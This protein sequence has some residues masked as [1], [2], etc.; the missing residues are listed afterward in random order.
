[1]CRETKYGTVLT[2]CQEIYVR[3]ILLARPSE[4]TA[5]VVTTYRGKELEIRT[6]AGQVSYLRL[7]QS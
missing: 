6:S 5:R 4:C 7:E 1:M 3:R 2:R